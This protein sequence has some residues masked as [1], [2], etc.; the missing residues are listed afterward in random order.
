M[1]GGVLA[2]IP[3]V[4]VVST[5]LGALPRPVPRPPPGVTP[6]ASPECSTPQSRGWLWGGWPWS[7]SL[8]RGWSSV[9]GHGCWL[10]LVPGAVGYV[11]G[12]CHAPCPGVTLPASPECLSPQCWGWLLGGR[13]VACW[14]PWL[15]SMMCS[16]R[17]FEVVGVVG[18][19]GLGR[20]EGRCW[21]WWLSMVCSTRVFDIV[22]VAAGRSPGRPGGRRR[23]RW[24]VLR[25]CL[26]LCAYLLAENWVVEGVVAVRC[27]CR[28]GWLFVC[29]T[30][31]LC[32][33]A[34][35]WVVVLAVVVVDGVFHKSVRCCGCVQWSW[36][37]S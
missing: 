31:W 34:E 32:S 13:R 15:L 18:G 30:S 19:R 12:C 28:W 33:M 35:V 29:S 26:T 27:R 5:S 2:H 24:R 8:T 36:Y 22:V 10:W 17:V 14:W 7:R 1:F 16:T 11:S 20:G 9:C 25:W 3:Q 6:P 23:C 37:G 21:P 4:D